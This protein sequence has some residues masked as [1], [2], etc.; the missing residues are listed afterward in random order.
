MPVIINLSSKGLKITQTV[1]TTIISA[2][3]NEDFVVEFS[4][5]IDLVESD[6]IF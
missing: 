2:D 4:G 6:F 1:D 3:N 5:F